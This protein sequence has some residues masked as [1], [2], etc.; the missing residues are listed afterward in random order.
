MKK[1]VALSFL[2]AKDMAPRVVASGEGILADLIREVAEKNSVEI[3]EDPYL[4]EQLI[5]VPE[6]EEIPENLYRA[7]AAVFAYL[8]KLEND[9]N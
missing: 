1:S 5:Q 8:H 6:G 4:A 3:V 9:L 7:V 2:P